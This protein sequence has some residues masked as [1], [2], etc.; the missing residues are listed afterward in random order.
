MTAAGERRHNVAHFSQFI[1]ITDLIKQGNLTAYF[2][3]TEAVL[4]W[5]CQVVHK[6]PYK[7]VLF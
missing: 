1:S 4:K 5:K 3:S 2:H 6:I 7:M